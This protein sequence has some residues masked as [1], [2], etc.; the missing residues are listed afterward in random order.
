MPT[1]LLL[2]MKV[3]LCKSYNPLLIKGIILLMV[4][5]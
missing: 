5:G 1:L 3:S 2:P 4:I